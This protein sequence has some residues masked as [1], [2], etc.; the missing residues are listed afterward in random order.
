M[1]LEL[2]TAW[3]S[4]YRKDP[5]LAIEWFHKAA[6]QGYAKAY[7]NLG[8]AYYNGDG[9]SV[10]DGASCVWFMLAAEA[11]DPNGQ[12]A[13]AR[14]RSEAAPDRI[15][16]CEAL[17]ASAYLRGELIK[18][19]L[20]RAVQW[21]TKS[22]NSDDSFACEQLAYLY[23]RRLGV[24]RDKQQSFNWLKRSAD[25]G[26]TPAVFELG[27]AYEAGDA[28]PKDLNRAKKLYERAA[29]TGEPNAL[30]AL[31]NLYTEGRGVKPDRQKAFMFYVLAADHGSTDGKHRA[32]E[33]EKQLTP[34]Q[35]AAAKQEALHFVQGNSKKPMLMVLK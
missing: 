22:A 35:I 29:H 15:V 27:M 28:V 26:Y 5:T 10:D 20:A 3:A 25:L 13:I 1:N 21:Y 6:H 16:H 14:T 33:L 18:Q 30:L 12:Q 9:V 24:Q 4:T 19:D 23:D 8:A 17:T 32:E 31:G 2:G 11:G 7:F 34:K